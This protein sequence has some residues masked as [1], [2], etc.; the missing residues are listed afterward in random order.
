MKKEELRKL[1]T[2]NATPAIIRD[3]KIKEKVKGVYSTWDTNKYSVL[4]RGQQLGKYIKIALF[5]PKH[6][7]AGTITPKYEVFIDLKAEKYITRVL[8]ASGNEV[9]W[10]SAMI[11]NLEGIDLWGWYSGRVGHDVYITQELKKTIKSQFKESGGKKLRDELEG[12]YRVF[13]WQQH[14][15]EADILE[16]ERRETKPWDDDQKLVPDLPKSFDEWMRKDVCKDIYVFYEYKPT[17]QTEGY[18]SSCKKTVNIKEPRHNKKTICPACRKS[19]VFKAASRSKT[20]GT[21]IY[22]GQIIQK[23]SGGLVIRCFSQQQSYGTKR[24]YTDPFIR[25][26]E[27]E[28]TFIFDDRTVRK[29]GYEMYKNKYQRWVLSSSRCTHYTTW[30][31][32]AMPLY[33]R[34]IKAIENSRVFE[35]SSVMLWDELPMSV[36]QFIEF[37]KGNPAIEMLAKIGM[38]DLA[39]DL[40]KERYDKNLLKQDATEIAKMLKIDNA[41]LKRL[42]LMG[43]RIKHLKWLQTEKRVDK[44]WPDEMMKGFA[45]NGI[46]ESDLGFLD[47][48][49]SYVKAYNY[50]KKQS[51]LM[52]EENLYQVMTTWRDY[53]CMADQMKM[54]TKLEQISHPKN[55]KLAHDEM[56]LLKNRNGIKEE[57]KKLKKKWPEAEKHME[58]LKKFEYKSGKYQI[59]APRTIEDIVKE[60]MILKHCV[61]TCDHYFLRIQTDESYL[62]FLR[63]S[64]SPDMPWYTLE[65]EPSGNIRQKRTTGDNQNKDFEEAIDFLKQWQQF[66][67]KQLTK[68]EKKLGEKSDLLRQ[69]NYRALR[70][71]QN[72]IWH[73][74]LAGQLLADV[75]E[76]DFMAVASC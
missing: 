4:C 12:L 34:N 74:K 31:R 27:W 5:M 54:N 57:A 29:Y 60:G 15:R 53:I 26:N 7:N 56:I 13:V 69:Q 61:H 43:G 70:K 67:Q 37:E 1:R 38:F 42:K 19:A 65:V 58:H 75:L 23:V 25:T 11:Y 32:E 52:D 28:R 9:K 41:R 10:S 45:D 55:L 30:W 72:K 73:G 39:R 51:K 47:A 64:D 24:T 20:L 22:Y 46:I 44:I 50:I 68:K 76:A 71:N 6:L 18:C 3:A 17:G 49:I 59:I 63:R 14:I 66:F 33:R 16:A 2:L 62:F 40:I 48:P 36:A 21:G 8:D 35:H